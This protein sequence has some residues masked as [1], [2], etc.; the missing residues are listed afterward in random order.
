MASNLELTTST[1]LPELREFLLEVFRMGPDAPFV[2]PEMM[3]VKYFEPAPDWN[4]PR[5]YLMFREGRIFAH[6]RVVPET[7]RPARGG[8]TSIRVIDLAG[9]RSVP[10][11]G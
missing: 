10:A 8:G 4:G 6:G 11:A 1:N 3:R 5:S 9:S 7:F 2:R